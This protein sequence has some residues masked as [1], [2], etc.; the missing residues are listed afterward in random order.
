MFLTC[1]YFRLVGPYLQ[2]QPTEEARSTVSKR[3][4]F[5]N[6]EIQKNEDSMK[7][8]QQQ[9]NAQREVLLTISKEAQRKQQQ[10]QH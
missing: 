5:I 1:R 8:L 6:S 10:Q 9:V 3:V 4:D 7:T 2:K